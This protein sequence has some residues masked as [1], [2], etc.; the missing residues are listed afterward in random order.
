MKTR[1]RKILVVDDEQAVRDLFVS[2]LGPA[3][4]D[5][6]TVADPDGA[7][8]TA[9]QIEPDI[10]YLSLLF[11]E[12]N[13]LKVGK[14]LHSIKRLRGIPIVVL[15]SYKGELDPKYTRTIGIVDVLVKPLNPA[16]IIAMTNRLLGEDIS[17]KEGPT[18]F[19]EEASK[20]P[21]PAE[22]AELLYA[23]ARSEDMAEVSGPADDGAEEDVLD[24]GYEIQEEEPGAGPYEESVN[25]KEPDL[26]DHNDE[27][28]EKDVD[29]EFLPPDESAGREDVTAVPQPEEEAFVGYSGNDEEVDESFLEAARKT[30]KSSAVKYVL[31]AALVLLVAAAVFAALQ[32]GIFQS[33]MKPG[34][35][36]T[37][38]GKE[39][40]GAKETVTEAVQPGKIEGGGR[41]EDVKTG[42]Q[43]REA[44]KT[45]SASSSAE[46]KK[47]PG[48]KRSVKP[49][50][51]ET[52]I[53]NEGLKEPK[54]FRG[55]HKGAYS[56]QVG[57][58]GEEGNAVSFARKLKKKG[59]EAFVE[60]SGGAG[61]HRVLIGR[62]DN[63]K[64]ALRESKVL[65]E[66]E[67]IKSIVYRH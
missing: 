37:A 61:L 44:S 47:K 65:L 23:G 51:E 29:G 62:F 6:A 59:Y 11:P 20:I 7:I 56:V 41:I 38:A 9:K 3:G 53:L 15:I 19:T 10:I 5:I 49:S 2:T 31:F 26:T 39:S 64:K 35:V 8:E 16:D 14:S 42:K 43:G 55:P 17:L 13:G 40:S 1:K 57:A 36:L 63:Y 28:K 48:L 46:P 58:F 24:L 34:K 60:K 32:T 12:S 27:E 54:T 4:L 30:R 22:D 18:D 50:P 45:L 21:T 66:K 25:V 67:G 52:G 33:G